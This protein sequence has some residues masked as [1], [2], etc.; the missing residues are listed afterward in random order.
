MSR[1]ALHRR[2]NCLR[3]CAASRGF[4]STPAH[5]FSAGG[6]VQTAASIIQSIHD[7]SSLPYGF[8][9][10]LTAVV[11]RTVVTLP[12]AI[13]SHNKMNRRI[14]LR[15]IHFFYTE[16]L[17]GTLKAV[18]HKTAKEI[19]LKSPPFQEITDFVAHL[20]DQ[21]LIIGKQ[22]SRPHLSTAWVYSISNIASQPYS[23][24]ALRPYLSGITVHVRVDR[25]V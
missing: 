12:L 6:G 16:W 25:C 8:T 2:V 22:T 4:A 15:P 10:P 23:N 7:F 21:L 17:T 1:I 9:I 20:S 5:L 19:N 24:S 14:E 11:L 18:Y 13:Y 3:R